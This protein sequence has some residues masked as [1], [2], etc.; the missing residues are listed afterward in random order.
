MFS[1][2]IAKDFLGWQ[3]WQ[4]ESWQQTFPSFSQRLKI[5]ISTWALNF[6]ILYIIDHLVEDDTLRIEVRFIDADF[7]D[8]GLVVGGIVVNDW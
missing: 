7:L 8:E 5:R 4:V 2:C 3:E 6:T 1:L